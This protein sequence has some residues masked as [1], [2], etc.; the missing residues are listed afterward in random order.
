[1]AAPYV[2]LCARGALDGLRRWCACSSRA[3]AAAWTPRPRLVRHGRRQPPSSATCPLCKPSSTARRPAP[4]V[5]HGKTAKWAGRPPEHMPKTPP[6][7]QA[8]ASAVDSNPFLFYVQKIKSHKNHFS[9]SGSYMTSENLQVHN[10]PNGTAAVKNMLLAITSHKAAVRTVIVVVAERKPLDKFLAILTATPTVPLA[11]QQ[12]HL[13]R[14]PLD[15]LADTNRCCQSQILQIN[16]ACSNADLTLTICSSI[17]LEQ[18]IPNL[19]N[20]LSMFKCSFNRNNMQL[21]YPRT[22]LTC[23]PQPQMAHLTERFITEQLSQ[24]LLHKD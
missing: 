9:S 4:C 18:Q 16:S 23:L 1:V 13:L 17:I 22:A 11:V 24:S 5:C 20:Q 2:H 6:W 7:L 8:A 10:L 21:H 14:L 3:L 19:A 15:S 12:H